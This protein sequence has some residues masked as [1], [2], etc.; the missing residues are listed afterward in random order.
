MYWA[1]KNTDTA[2]IFTLCVLSVHILLF[3]DFLMS[4]P[5]LLMGLG[6]VLFFFIV[7][8]GYFAKWQECSNIKTKLFFHSVCYRLLGVAGMYMLTMMYDPSNL[9]FDIKGIDSWN[10]HYSGII[11]ADAI[12]QDRDLFQALSFFWKSKSDYGFS[13]V[14]GFLYSIFGKFPIVIKIFNVIVGSYTVVRIYQITKIIYAEQQARIAGII[15]MLM[16]AF[17]WFGGMFLK[18]TILMFL[19]INTAYYAIRI[20]NFPNLRIVYILLLMSHFGILFYF[21]TVL[22]PII[23]GAAMLQIAFYKQKKKRHLLLSIII[24]TTLLISSIYVMKMLSMYDMVEKTVEASSD[25]FGNELDQASKNRG[26]NYAAAL[27]VP[28]LIAGAIITPFPSLLDFEERQ[29]P[30]YSHY[31]NEIIRNIMYFFVFLGL[32]RAIKQKNKKTIY[33]GSFALIYIMILAASGISF[34]DRFQV[35]SLP[36]LIIFM[37]DGVVSNYPKKWFHWKIYLLFIFLGILMWNVFK[38]SNRGLI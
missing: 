7:M 38:L 4:L 2:I 3:S 22:P 29:L 27:V 31:Q 33:V 10:Y 5:V 13:M 6:I 8:N 16:P 30:I 20:T 35:L 28:L 32:I 17:L 37:A 19:L 11:A 34:Q 26:I 9:P 18:E 24:I 25:Q 12:N 15:T 21:R 1:K 23:L 14:I 36:F